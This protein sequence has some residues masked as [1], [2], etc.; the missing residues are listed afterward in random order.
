MF[1]INIEYME[2]NKYECRKKD[3]WTN[4]FWVFR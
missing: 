4:T 3:A 2:E 1:V